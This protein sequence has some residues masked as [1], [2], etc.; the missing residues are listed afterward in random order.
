MYD[1]GF[2]LKP[3]LVLLLPY[4]LQ[5]LSCK[6]PLY[7]VFLYLLDVA[8]ALPRIPRPD[9]FRSRSTVSLFAAVCIS[10]FP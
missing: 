9:R 2:M 1:L 10:V 5:V 8:C 3:A 7:H 4:V 6:R